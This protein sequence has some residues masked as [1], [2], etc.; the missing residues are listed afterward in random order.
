MFPE[1]HGFVAIAVTIKLHQTYMFQ[2]IPIKL[3]NGDK[4]VDICDRHSNETV[5]LRKH[6]NKYKHIQKWMVEFLRKFDNRG[7]KIAGVN[8]IFITKSVNLL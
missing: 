4:I 8:S 6:V 2:C 7:I 1:S 5:T 3:V